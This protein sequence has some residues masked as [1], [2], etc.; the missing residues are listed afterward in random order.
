MRIQHTIKAV[1]RPGAEWGFVAECLEIAVVTRGTTLDETVANL[2]EAVGL[3]L[4]GEDLEDLALAGHP[5][6]LVALACDVALE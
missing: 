1:I 4:D 6:I 2:Q 3:Y 5:T